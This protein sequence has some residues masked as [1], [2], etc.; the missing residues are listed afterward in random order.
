MRRRVAATRPERMRVAG[1]NR[2]DVMA[3]RWNRA[4]LVKDEVGL[5]TCSLSFKK[6]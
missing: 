3:L 5:A 1:E 2:R 4:V 6:L